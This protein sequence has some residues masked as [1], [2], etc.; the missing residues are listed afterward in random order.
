M[1]NYYMKIVAVEGEKTKVCLFS[2]SVPF[3]VMEKEALA[4]F[5]G[6]VTV[7]YE[8]VEIK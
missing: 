7:T 6:R 4:G 8:I 3:S 2:L 1:K 5:T